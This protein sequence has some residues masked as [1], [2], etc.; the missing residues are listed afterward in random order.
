M[1]Q[2]NLQ[3]INLTSDKSASPVL[4]TPGSNQ[5]SALTPNLPPNL[6]P[7]VE[8]PQPS[9]LSNLG[10]S[11]LQ[12][13]GDLDGMYQRIK[14]KE[15]QIN[16]RKLMDTNSLRT[17]RA[18]LIQQFFEFMQEQGIDPNNLESINKFLGQLQT[19]D[20]DLF[21]LFNLSFAG[22][23]KQEDLVPAD[24]ESKTEPG[25]EPGLDQRFKNIQK[26]MLRYQK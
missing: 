6:T 26:Q 17:L 8:A 24:A 11:P 14:S 25:V 7:D 13:K 3:P 15:R 12:M 18:K 19:Q 4:E 16:S 9:S 5:I 1:P 23:M 2:E 21:E 20:P 10:M 22:L